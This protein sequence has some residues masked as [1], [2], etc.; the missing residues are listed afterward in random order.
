MVGIIAA[1]GAINYGIASAEHIYTVAGAMNLAF[2]AFG[3][4]AAW[5][6]WRQVHMPPGG[7]RW[8]DN[9]RSW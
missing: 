8:L 6:K 3:L 4:R 1:V 2:V 7:F 9:L 5:K